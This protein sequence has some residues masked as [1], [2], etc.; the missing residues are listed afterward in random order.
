MNSFC[1]VTINFCKN[2]EV[3]V[4]ISFLASSFLQNASNNCI[5]NNSSKSLDVSCIISLPDF[6]IAIPVSS[7]MD[8]TFG[9]LTLINYLENGTVITQV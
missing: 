5:L 7:S 6:F 9:K 8:M 2:K 1:A 3:I 4:F